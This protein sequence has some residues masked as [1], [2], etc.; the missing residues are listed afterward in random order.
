MQLTTGS[1]AP[2][3]EALNQKGETIRSKDLLGKKVVLYFY[4]KDDT[5]ACTQ[6]ACDLRDNHTQLTTQGY[7]V[8]G[9]SPDDVKSHQKF[10]NKYEL[11]FMLLADTDHAIA[12][13]FGVWQEKS[14][15]GKKYMGIVRTTF[16]INEEGNITNIISKI[17]TAEHS[18]QILA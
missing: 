13:K 15:Y 6:Q 1:K 11:P 12:E 2:E 16:L 17:K 9:V 7:T 5:K 3:F 8:I 14:M 18:K 4:P 10:I